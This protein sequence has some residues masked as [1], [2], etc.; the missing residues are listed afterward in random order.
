MA[1]SPVFNCVNCINYNHHQFGES[2]MQKY[3]LI[4]LMT[5]AT[6]VGYWLSRRRETETFD[7]IE[8]WFA[9]TLVVS[10]SVSSHRSGRI[11]KYG[12]QHFERYRVTFNWLPAKACD[13]SHPRCIIINSDSGK[14]LSVKSDFCRG[15]LFLFFLSTGRIVGIIDILSPWNIWS[16]RLRKWKQNK[17]KKKVVQLLTKVRDN[18]KWLR[19]F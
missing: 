7:K 11:E 1:Y 15:L 18:N 4:E 6:A 10:V 3:L 2:P 14:Y 12:S 8:S 19:A 17:N 16:E 9:C 13:E 5:D